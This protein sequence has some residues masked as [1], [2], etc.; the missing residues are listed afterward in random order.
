MT[1]TFG[2][3]IR[4]RRHT[5]TLTSDQL[6]QRM[7]ARGHAVDIP[8]LENGR[9]ARQEPGFLNALASALEWRVGTLRV[10]RY[11]PGVTP[12]P[13]A[14]GTIDHDRVT[15]E[16]TMI[17]EEMVDVRELHEMLLRWTDELTTRASDLRST[18]RSVGAGTRFDA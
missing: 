7:H 15:D 2:D 9:F 6:A 14:P 5:L 13:A 16:A 12:E 10:A 4:Y 3:L 11:F 17:R 1:M 18:A 8:A